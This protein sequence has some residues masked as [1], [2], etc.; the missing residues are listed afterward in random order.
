MKITMLGTGNA[1]AT[2]CYNTCFLLTG[3]DD[4][5]LL[6]DGGGGNA[7]LSRLKLAGTD[8]RDIRDIFVTHKHIDH[9]LG[10]IWMVRMICQ[11][12]S[13]GTYD[14]EAQIYAHDEAAA[15][16][17]DLAHKLL[18][19]KESAFVGNRLRLVTVSDGG[20]LDIIGEKFTFFDIR[21]TKAKQYGF[22]MDLGGG[23]KL[24]CCGDEPYNECGRGYAEGS[25][26]LLHEAFCLHS[27]A[28]KFKPYEKHHSTVK[29][30]CEL[31]ERL[32]VENLLLYHTEDHN[33]KNRKELYTAE[34]RRYFHGNIFVPNDLETIEL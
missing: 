1:T 19:A 25:K 24:T 17:G 2:E 14:G 23:D 3:R 16:I 5:H 10:V 29:D 4:R 21:S 6:V 30:A 31:A 26:W 20:E 22:I 15:L 7:I 8:W 27:Q 32:G 18:G 13:R 12:M 33:I 28:D 34:G 9:L 11:N